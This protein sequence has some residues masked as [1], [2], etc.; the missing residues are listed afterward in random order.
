[1]ADRYRR[2]LILRQISLVT[3]L[4]LKP[5]PRSTM[6]RPTD[7]S[8]DPPGFLLSHDA[9]LGAS[10]LNPCRAI[11]V[12]IIGLHETRCPAKRRARRRRSCVTVTT[13][14][15]EIARAAYKSRSRTNRQFPS[16]FYSLAD[17]DRPSRTSARGIARSTR[18][19]SSPLI[20][21]IDLRRP[22][23][24]TVNGN[25]R[26]RASPTASANV[27]LGLCEFPRIRDIS[28]VLS[29]TEAHGTPK[30]S[31]PLN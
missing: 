22:D 18:T 6:G 11:V 16:Q 20:D 23:A 1:M 12:D 28:R 24:S 2:F 4:L 31:L 30:S 7:R 27:W 3:R 8:I 26:G 21:V 25:L 10:A 14:S 13:R 29:S 15:R 17:D 19:A 5:Y 9:I